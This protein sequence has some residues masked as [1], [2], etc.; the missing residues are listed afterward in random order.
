MC[1]EVRLAL[2]GNFDQFHHVHNVGQIVEGQLPECL[3]VAASPAV[4]E[5]N[6]FETIDTLDSLIAAESQTSFNG[7]QAAAVPERN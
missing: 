4:P 5:P 6:R 2:H 1:G 3:T 7:L